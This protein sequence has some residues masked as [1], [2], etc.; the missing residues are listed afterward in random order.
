METV[1]RYWIDFLKQ[2]HSSLQDKC[3]LTR[4]EF[5]LKEHQVDWRG[6]KIMHSSW[7]FVLQHE[8][9]HSV[10]RPLSKLLEYYY[11]TFTG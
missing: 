2:N 3:H 6:V 1:W 7:K 10:L 5:Y 8:F 9:I 11:V 4:L